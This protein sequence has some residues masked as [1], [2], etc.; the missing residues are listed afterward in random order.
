[1]F[2]RKFFRN[3]YNE[4]ER[5]MKDRNNRH[6]HLSIIHSNIKRSFTLMRSRD[7]K[8][9]IDVLRSYLTYKSRCLD[10]EWQKSRVL[11][12]TIT[13]HPNPAPFSMYDD[14]REWSQ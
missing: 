14:V 1:M 7:L 9:L 8:L 11:D 4:D 2:N 12:R 5:T 13:T 3:D 10:I 6:K